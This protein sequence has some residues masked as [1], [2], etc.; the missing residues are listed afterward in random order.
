MSI[1]RSRRNQVGGASDMKDRNN[2][3]RNNNRNGAQFV[4]FD[5]DKFDPNVFMDD[6][7]PVPVGSERAVASVTVDRDECTVVSLNGVVGLDNDANAFRTVFMR[8]YRGNGNV[9]RPDNV[10]YDAYIEIHAEGQ[11]DVVVE[12]FAH[13]DDD[14]NNHRKKKCNKNHDDG[15]TTYTLTLEADGADVFLVGPLTFTAMAVNK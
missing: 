1:Y 6:F 11:N 10:I 12:P 8:I 5:Y 15:E 4:D 9:L 14:D 2:H 13:V 7:I 3:N